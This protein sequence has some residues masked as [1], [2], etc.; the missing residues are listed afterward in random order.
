MQIPLELGIAYAAS[1]S[2]TAR[3]GFVLN[4]VGGIVITAVCLL[5]LE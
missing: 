1:I 5:I 4:L 3:A 2:D